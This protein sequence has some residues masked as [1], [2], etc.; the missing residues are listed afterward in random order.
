MADTLVQAG[1]GILIQIKV[2]VKRLPAVPLLDRRAPDDLHSWLSRSAWVN[3]T[4][5][6]DRLHTAPSLR[7]SRVC[8]TVDAVL[9]AL[10]V[11]AALIHLSLFAG[12]SG[13]A[14]GV[15]LRALVISTLLSA[16]PV[17]ILWFLD[18]RERE[19]PWLLAAAFLWGACIATALSVPFNTAFF[20]LVDRWIALNPIVGEV[21][22]PDATLLITAPLSAPVVE[23]TIK[24]AG[25][26]L[27]FWLLR[28]EFDG[29][30]DG[31]IYGALVGVGFN[32]FEA[33]L[34]VMQGYLQHGVAPYA[35]QL[36][37][38]YGLLGLG[39]HAM[40]TG[41]FGLFLGLAAQT[42]RRWLQW[43]APAI[44]LLLAVAAHLLNNALPLLMALAAAAEGQPPA[45]GGP[46]AAQEIGFLQALVS[47]SILHLTTFLPFTLIVVI[48]LWYSGA[49]ERRVIREELV[50]EIGRVVTPG[51]YHAIVKHRFLRPPR[52]DELH[53]ERSAAL[54]SAQHELAFRKRRV[55]NEGRDPEHDPLVVGWRHDIER[56]RRSG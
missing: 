27:I 36:G 18:R 33:P 19:S 7:K 53:P 16:V 12:L 8:G 14:T 17:S 40:F 42:S 2:R 47:T 48:A 10:L 24:A 49:W 30:R 26:A 29:M 15:F 44:G 28:D 56:L 41:L 32:W 54:V 21:L 34:F 38:R 50:S 45:Q 43:L 37:V 31:F 9:V 51:E 1:L 3:P 25:V 39:G 13:E 11:I 23:E 46:E 4:S 35:Q 6:S 20:R 52:I 55:R 5:S 22:G